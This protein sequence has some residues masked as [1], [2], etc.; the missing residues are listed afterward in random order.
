LKTGLGFI[1]DNWK[2]HRVID[3]MR[4]PIRLPQLLRRYLVSFARYVDLLVEKREIFIPNLYFAS[5]QW[6]TP[7]EF[8]EDV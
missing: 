1:E 2:W 5:P 8:S 4:V 6:V 7:S 3:L